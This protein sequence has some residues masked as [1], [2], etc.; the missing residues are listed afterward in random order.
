MD[1]SSAHFAAAAASAQTVDQLLAQTLHALDQLT[2]I[3]NFPRHLAQAAIEEC[4]PDDVTRCYNWILDNHGDEATDGGG[5][6]VPRTDCPHI[7]DRVKFRVVEGR[8]QMVDE[9]GEFAE[10]GAEFRRLC[11]EGSL[12]DSNC[13]HHAAGA[14]RRRA[15]RK[16]LRSEDDEHCVTHESENRVGRPKDEEDYESATATEGGGKGEGGNKQ[17]RPCP[18]GENWLCLE[19]GLLLCS[20]YAHGHAR[21]HYEDTKEEEAAA[22]AARADDMGDLCVGKQ[23]LAYDGRGGLEAEDPKKKAV[24]HCVAVSLADLSVWCYECDAYLVHPTLEKITRHLEG[25]K[26]GTGGENE[27][28]ALEKN[29]EEMEQDGPTEEMDAATGASNVEDDCAMEEA[30]EVSSSPCLNEATIGAIGDGSDGSGE[31]APS[32]GKRKSAPRKLP[33]ELLGTTMPSHEQQPD[34]ISGDRADFASNNGK[35]EGDSSSSSSEEVR[36]PSGDDGKPKGG[37]SSSSDDEVDHQAALLAS[38]LSSAHGE[39]L[40]AYLARH[41]SFHT[42]NLGQ[43]V[44]MH[45]PKPPTFPEEV[46][47]FLKSPLCKSI[48]VLA[49][50]GM[51][52]SSG[53]PDFRSAGIGLYDTLRPELLTA[54]E[55]ERTLIEDDP[56]LALDKGLFLQNPLPML[57][58]K[59][60][61]I[62]GTQSKRWKATLAHRFVEMLHTK[63]GKL[64]RL[65]TQN[66][67]GLEAQTALPAEKVVCVHGSMGAAACEVCGE[68]VDFDSFCDKVR[69]NIK[70]ITGQDPDAPRES[71]P[72]TCE[73]CG[74]PTLKPTIV[75]FRGS[76]PKEFHVRTA[77]DLPDCDLLIVMGTSL[78]VAPANSLVYRVPPTALRMVINNERI[79]RRLGIDYSENSIRDVFAE[80]HSDETCLELADKMGWLED[81]AGIVDEL[82]EAPRRATTQHNEDDEDDRDAVGDGAAQTRTMKTIGTLWAMGAAVAAGDAGGPSLREENAPHNP[83]RLRCNFRTQHVCV[84]CAYDDDGAP[85][86]EPYCADESIPCPAEVCCDLVREEACHDP[87]TGDATHCAKLEEGGCPCPEGEEKCGA[88]EYS[89]GYCT[90]LCC[91]ST[92]KTCYDLDGEAL[93]C[94]DE[95]E[96]CPKRTRG[97]KRRSCN[98]ETE[99]M[100]TRCTYLGDGTAM[101]EHYCLDNEEECP[102]LVCCDVKTEETCYDAL[103]GDATHCARLDEG[104]CPCPEGEER[105]GA[106]DYSSGFCTRLCCDPETTVET[107][108]DENHVPVLCRREG[109]KP[110]PKRKV[111]AEAEEVRCDPDTEETCHDGHGKPIFC[112]RE[113]DHPCPKPF[114]PPPDVTMAME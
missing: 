68:S 112:R 13:Q 46:A 25:V 33:P 52:V 84:R 100:C 87:I 23:G 22:L 90:T 94:V 76:M 104:G 61:F 34:S 69:S 86:P 47:D 27:K 26:F 59:R 107:C 105:C 53:I 50:A 65:Y 37:D 97:R 45:M 30:K 110:C 18:K 98:A 31:Q 44:P 72:I 16:R 24:G 38:L 20:R 78:T 55:L 88:N 91:T 106:N 113:G 82:P 95:G 63:L 19:C 99:Q 32:F 103:T 51:S 21:R 42:S 75:L 74:N 49:G 81:L 83:N 62:L 79:G 58:T 28:D 64:T 54:T 80:G 36:S 66:I 77:E 60:S 102:E 6:V 48:V 4:G 71:T 1:S 96:R 5:P 39:A 3:F 92:E 114:L 15:S 57:E 89:S 93:L 7:G 73:A 111:P 17:P 8:L 35:T 10:L 11:L 9:T 40:R 43:C 41:E 67:D 85:S 109:D 70:D 2:T 101:P 14:L 108:Y 12:M 29:A 56:T